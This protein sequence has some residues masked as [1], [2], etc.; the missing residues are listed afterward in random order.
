MFTQINHN[1]QDQSILQQF[2]ILKC[3]QVM[4]KTTVGYKVL[5]LH[6]R[7][8]TGHVYAMNGTHFIALMRGGLTSNSKITW[9]ELDGI[10][11]IYDTSY[12]KNELPTEE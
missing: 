4:V 11:E 10:E 1:I 2:G 9:V 6:R 3:A 7:D 5:N 12:L 8:S